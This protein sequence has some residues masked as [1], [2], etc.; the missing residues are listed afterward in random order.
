VA[1]AA[2]WWIVGRPT[3]IHKL[4]TRVGRRRL[5]ALP[6]PISD[7]RSDE[8]RTEGPE[9]F[10]AL[11]GAVGTDLGAVSRAL[12]DALRAVD[13]EAVEIRLSELLDWVDWSTV[14]DGSTQ[15]D[16]GTT[17]TH[18]ASR[19]EAGD[20]LREAVNRGDALA[21][22]AILKIRR[23]RS[24]HDKPEPRRAY[25]LRSLKHPDEVHTL[26]EVYGPNFF[27]ISA[28]TPVE[29]RAQALERDIAHDWERRV[30]DTEGRSPRGV[31]WNLIERDRSEADRPYGQKLDDTFSQADV[32]VDGREHQGL[33]R[34]TS[35]F[36]ELIFNHPFHTPTRDENAMF[37][38]QAA[39]L[40][41]AA[42]GRQVGAAIT[43]P[44]GNVVS[45]GTNEVP[46]A[47]GG[48][49]WSGDQNDQRD[50][51]RNDPNVSGTE[52]S[53]VIEQIFHRLRELGWLSK[54]AAER[55]A[56][57]FHEL[58][59]GL[60]VHNLIEF[61]RAV[62]AEMAAIVDAARRGVS[63]AG[64]Y[65]YA[66]TFPCHECTRHVIASGISRL[67]YIAPYP[68]SL[69]ARLHDDALVVDP[70]EQPTGRVAFSPFVG[71]APR[72][73]MELFTPGEE[74]RKKGDVVSSP[75]AGRLPKSVPGL[76]GHG[77]E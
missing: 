37:H 21:L 23:L 49:Y 34:E 18:I 40:R 53:T 51:N 36:I 24:D 63:I 56:D 27:L 10:F 22:L 77:R 14:A 52:K 20:R 5:L 12:V 16:D 3:S 13:Y 38:A 57:E 39:S 54:D 30:D 4:L 8:E 1:R 72:R 58:L 46:K 2:C 25:V 35:R 11:A 70:E 60:R 19:M 47:G 75:V 62:H 31:A 44:D 48:Q 50:H 42:P 71:V 68:K 28:Y 66:T 15:L 17:D 9:L 67:V 74:A 59:R 26:R 65:L 73:Y 64:C 41:S 76:L 6:D 32:F 7:D 55:D 33:A 43:S 45:L 61:E 29:M 69:A